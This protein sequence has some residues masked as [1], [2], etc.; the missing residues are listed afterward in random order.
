MEVERGEAVL[1]LTPNISYLEK[2]KE[3]V[4]KVLCFYFWDPKYGK[5]SLLIDPSF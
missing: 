2:Y 5:G 4:L 3:L 1:F